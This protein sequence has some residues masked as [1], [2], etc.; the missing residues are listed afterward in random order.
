[1]SIQLML[2]KVTVRE[3][4]PSS[5]LAFALSSAN[6]PFAQVVDRDLIIHAEASTVSLK[7]KVF[8]HSE[9]AQLRK[10]I[11]KNNLRSV[12]YQSISRFQGRRLHSFSNSLRN[13]EV[14]WRQI[15]G[16]LV[17]NS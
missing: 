10:A 3:E 4:E 5:A 11:G 16:N 6:E 14:F 1:M 8:N 17:Q 2:K 9:F 7:V 12:A 13:L 15:R